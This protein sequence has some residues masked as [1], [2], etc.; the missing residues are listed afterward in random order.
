[1]QCNKGTLQLKK[2][3]LIVYAEFVLFLIFPNR[4]KKMYEK[5]YFLKNVLTPS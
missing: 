2:G 4:L 1:M 5:D 3:T